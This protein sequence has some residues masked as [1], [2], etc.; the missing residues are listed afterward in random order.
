MAMYG[1]N[2]VNFGPAF[3][4]FAAA[5]NNNNEQALQQAKMLQDIFQAN[6]FA[7]NTRY[8]DLESE[9]YGQMT[10]FELDVKGLEAAKARALNT[11]GNIDTLT[12]GTLGDALSKKAKG[13]E[14]TETVD[15]RIKE[16]KTKNEA[17]VRLQENLTAVS[18]IE[19]AA[20]FAANSGPLAGKVFDDYLS[21]LP[22][23]DLTNSLRG[24]YANLGKILPGLKQAVLAESS[25]Y[26]IDSQTAKEKF[27]YDEKI[28]RIREAAANTRAALQEKNLDRRAFETAARTSSAEYRS[29]LTVSERAIRAAEENSDSPIHRGQ[30]ISALKNELKGKKPTEAQI[31]ARI[32]EEKDRLT[33]PYRDAADAAAKTAEAYRVASTLG[34]EKGSDHM[35]KFYEEQERKKVPTLTREEA[36]EAA[37]KLILDQRGDNQGSAPQKTNPNQGVSNNQNVDGYGNSTEFRLPNLDLRRIEGS[38]PAVPVIN[39]GDQ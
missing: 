30:V 8:K 17:A 37:R 3:G 13:K 34:A 5:E 26:A 9:R 33:K 38:A 14:D 32:K 21:T 19:K 36:R 39:Y 24:N 23:S 27:G 4:G 18:G 2:N 29:W 6:N 28:A 16:T 31:Q 22:P 20:A 12:A 15:S 10:P 1:L 7:A 35:R 11:P 25:R